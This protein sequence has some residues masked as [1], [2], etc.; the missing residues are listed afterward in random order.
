MALRCMSRYTVYSNNQQLKMYAIAVA[1]C[2]TMQQ[3]NHP[4]SP[5]QTG[6]HINSHWKCG[7][8]KSGVHL[9]LYETEKWHELT[10][11][12]SLQYSKVYSTMYG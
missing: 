7:F 6:P 10:N 9:V 12:Y 3:S 4:V 5:P 2:K 1:E 11:E 8:C